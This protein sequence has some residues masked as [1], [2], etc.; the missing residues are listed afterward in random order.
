MNLK[1]VPDNAP[2]C[3]S[4]KRP[5]ETEARALGQLSKA[6]E[7]RS[8]VSGYKPGRVENRAYKCAGCGWWHLTAMRRKRL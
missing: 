4:G 5:F 7:R 3:T 6:K 1:D 8:R 2:L